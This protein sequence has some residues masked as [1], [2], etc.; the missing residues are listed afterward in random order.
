MINAVFGPE[1]G[2]GAFRDLYRMAA[3]SLAR[4]NLLVPAPTV[5]KGRY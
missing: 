2:P 3:I 4:R 1:A 5:V